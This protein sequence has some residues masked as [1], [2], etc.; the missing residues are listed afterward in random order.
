MATQKPLTLSA[1]G[2]VQ[3]LPTNDTLDL[4]TLGTGTADNTTFLRGDG[5]WVTPPSEATSLALSSL[6][7]AVDTN[8]IVSGDNAQ[9]WQWALTSIVK[10]GLLLT[11]NAASINGGENQV[12]LDVATL[13]TSTASPL[14][15]LAR[16]VEA[17]RVNF[18]GNVGIG[19]S[20]PVTKLDVAG[21]VTASGNITATTFVGSGAS[22]T[23]IPSGNLLGTIPT[24][25]LGNS[26][27]YLGTTAIALNRSSATQA[28]T[29]IT[30]IDGSATTLTTPR[31]INGVS[32]DG[33]SNIT[34]T[35]EA[36]DVYTWA[37]APAKPTYTASEVNA[38]EIH[39]PQNSQSANYTLVLADQGKHIFHP[40][41]D[42]TARTF[43][44]P[45]NVSVAFLIGTAVTFINQNAGGVITI[46]ITTDVMRLAGAG[47]TGN[48]TLAANG[49][50]TAIKVT[51]TEWIIYGPGLT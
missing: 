40:S 39:I 46:A 34:I 33:S 9:I 32:F 21:S 24:T 7:A 45:S 12:L 51:S 20:T 1:T 10:S 22:L 36:S 15:V 50:A 16:G 13:A 31:M 6:T 26:T 42:T 19:T 4:G 28:L 5:T 18:D 38:A 35:A 23:S 14:R 43:T 47:T 8:T 11:E 49:V 48:R 37:K 25:V 29:G 41:S 17:V 44:I 2:Q 27:L 30:S 3:R